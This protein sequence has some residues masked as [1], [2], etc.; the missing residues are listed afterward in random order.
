M[1]FNV[2]LDYSIYTFTLNVSGSDRWVDRDDMHISKRRATDIAVCFELK[3]PEEPSPGSPWFLQSKASG[4]QC[5]RAL[6][7]ITRQI[8]CSSFSLGDGCHRNYISKKNRR[9]NACCSSFQAAG[10]SPQYSKRLNIPEN[11]PGQCIPKP[12]KG[13]G[14]T[15]TA[16]IH[17]LL[18]YSKG[19]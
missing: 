9:R 11:A 15:G 1:T 4:A 18:V 10:K 14:G 12:G 5:P 2:Q 3:E 7:Y 8:I 13:D 17:N 6:H 19:T 16:Y